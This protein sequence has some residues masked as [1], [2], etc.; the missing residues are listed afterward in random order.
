[1]I[2]KICVYKACKS[3]TIATWIPKK[4]SLLVSTQNCF[5]AMILCH[6][7]S[8]VMCDVHGHGHVMM[9]CLLSGL[10]FIYQQCVWLVHQHN[11]Y[12]LKK[13]KFLRK[14][15]P[16]R[17]TLKLRSCWPWRCFNQSG[18]SLCCMDLK[19]SAHSYFWTRN[20]NLK[21]VVFR[22]KQL[23][24]CP[25]LCITLIGYIVEFIFI[26]LYLFCTP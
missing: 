16:D 7:D 22:E 23:F 19:F 13:N 2:L 5:V 8:C 20:L 25:G 4:A 15:R 12:H 17:T 14:T 11:S 3:L 9:T 10:V 26:F 1:M 21:S 24:F 18:L 6:Y